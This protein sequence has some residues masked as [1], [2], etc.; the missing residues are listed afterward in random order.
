MLETM[1]IKLFSF[2]RK[3]KLFTNFMKISTEQNWALLY[4]GTFGQKKNYP[5]L[6][7]STSR[8][9]GVTDDTAIDRGLFND[10]TQQPA[11]VV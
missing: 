9:P 3:L 1:L 5:S 11:S 2:F 4:L 8:I 7:K 10:T 6:G